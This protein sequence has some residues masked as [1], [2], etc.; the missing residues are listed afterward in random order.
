MIHTKNTLISRGI[1]NNN[2]NAGSTMYMSKSPVTSYFPLSPQIPFISIFVNSDTFKNRIYMNEEDGLFLETEFDTYYR[3]N[4]MNENNE[5]FQNAT[6]AQM[7]NL[8]KSLNE[9]N[10]MVEEFKQFLSNRVEIDSM[11]YS[12]TDENSIFKQQPPKIQQLYGHYI[13]QQRGNDNSD[14][15]R[16]SLIFSQGETVLSEVDL[17]LPV[18]IMNF[19]LQQT[20]VIVVI[21]LIVIMVTLLGM[22]FWNLFILRKLFHFYQLIHLMK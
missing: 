13:Q 11:N 8:G 10:L 3:D 6:F 4:N 19:L 15:V 21:L 2:N 12:E 22:I 1:V 5:S 16:Q 7:M 18:L 17:S 9:F 20:I 14:K